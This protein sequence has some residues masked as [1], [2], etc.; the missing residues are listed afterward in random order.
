MDY[1]LFVKIEKVTDNLESVLEMSGDNYNNI[2]RGFTGRFE[3]DI[4]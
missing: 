2:F 1:S 4:K 3:S